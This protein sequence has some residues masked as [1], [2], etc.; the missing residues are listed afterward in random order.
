MKRLNLTS[1]EYLKLLAAKE[2]LF[3]WPASGK[4][5]QSISLIP[6]HQEVIGAVN[7]YDTQDRLTAIFRETPNAIGGVETGKVGKLKLSKWLTKKNI[8]EG[9]VSQFMEVRSK[10]RK[11]WV[12]SIDPAV[13]A[14]CGDSG[15]FNSCYRSEH[16]YYGSCIAWACATNSIMFA[17]DDGDAGWQSRILLAVVPA[18]KNVC[19]PMLINGDTYNCTQSPLPKIREWLY[20]QI[21]E[22]RDPDFRI[23]AYRE[24]AA[25][26]QADITKMFPSNE[27]GRYFDTLSKIDT[28]T[29]A[30]PGGILMSKKVFGKTVMPIHETIFPGWN[31]A[32][33]RVKSCDKCFTIF[34]HMT[35]TGEDRRLWVC[36][37]CEAQCTKCKSVNAQTDMVSVEGQMYCSTCIVKCEKCNKPSMADNIYSMSVNKKHKLL[38]LSCALERCSTFPSKKSK[39]KKTNLFKKVKNHVSVLDI[40]QI[41]ALLITVHGSAPKKDKEYWH[42]LSPYPKMPLG[43]RSDNDEDVNKDGIVNMDLIYVHHDTGE[44]ERNYLV[45]NVDNQSLS[46]IYDNIDMPALK[47]HVLTFN[48]WSANDLG[49]VCA[50]A[51]LSFRSISGS[52]NKDKR[53][54]AMAVLAKEGI[55]YIHRS[56]PPMTENAAKK[57]IVAAQVQVTGSNLFVDGKINFKPVLCGHMTTIKKM[58]VGRRGVDFGRLKERLA[59]I[60]Q[61]LAVASGHKVA[62]DCFTVI[63]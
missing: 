36:P 31:M 60:N 42:E 7:N 13:I 26:E 62:K 49:Q 34:R 20:K 30:I 41:G 43:F 58:D 9:D 29:L 45:D 4:I 25:A 15:H 10:L 61:E 6:N 23:C 8:S 57:T 51:E 55:L 18:I 12:V 17:I 52:P 27:T 35:G 53:F 40:K 37:N 22:E 2:K 19:P 44:P 48:Q 38:C 16:E 5:P 28:K 21:Q 50:P 46:T 3:Q 59:K 24:L 33:D 1:K 63:Y 32:L 54:V 14:T 47:K 39:A 56:L 11:K